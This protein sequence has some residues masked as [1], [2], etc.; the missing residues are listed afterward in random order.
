MEWLIP[1]ASY[2]CLPIEHLFSSVARIRGVY[3]DVSLASSRQQPARLG[4]IIFDLLAKSTDVNIHD[5]L[6]ID[7]P[8]HPDSFQ[9][10]LSAKDTAGIAHQI[11]KQLELFRAQLL[12]F[13]SCFYG[14]F[15][16]IWI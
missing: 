7:L 10:L 2:D 4:G 13:C 9:Q 12:A 11:V 3:Q 14:D 5:S 8:R 15:H 16:H 6:S 1:R